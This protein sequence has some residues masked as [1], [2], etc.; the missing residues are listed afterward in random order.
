MSAA[1]RAGIPPLLMALMVGHGAIACTLSPI[2]AAG[3]VAN[4]ILDGMSLGG[5]AWWLYACNAAANAAAAGSGF[6]LFGGWG[7]FRRRPARQDGIDDLAMEAET[8]APH[9]LPFLPRHGVT[10]AVIAA[11]IVAV[12]VGK[13]HIGMAAFAGAALLSLLRLADE[14]ETS[15]KVPWSVIVMVCGVSTLAA[16]LNQTGGARRFAELIGMISTPATLSGVIAFV[17]GIVSIYSST[18]GVVLPAFLPMVTDLAAVH[19]DSD[20]LGLAVSVLIGGNLVDMSPLSTIGA[21][22]LA[23]APEGIDRRVLFHQL[24]AWGFA[25]SVAG[26]VVCWAG[27]GGA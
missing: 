18:T 2:T 3:V 14:R 8:A 16:L 23:A 15:Q 12:V 19:P 1:A 21:L 20:P 7:L 6:L 5:H 4:Q 22:C 13:A 10:L 25:M 24:L 27:W 9:R 17:A 26:A 11:L